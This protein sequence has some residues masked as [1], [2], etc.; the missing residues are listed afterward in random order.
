MGGS[1]STT[2]IV[3]VGLGMY[4]WTTILVP[5]DVV[6]CV[7]CAMTRQGEPEGQ[8]SINSENKQFF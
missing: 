4:I 6:Y 7:V 1:Y 5:S 3:L 2:T 8:N